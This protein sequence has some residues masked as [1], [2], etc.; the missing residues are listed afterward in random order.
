MIFLF[1]PNNHDTSFQTQAGIGSAPANFGIDNENINL[2]NEKIIREDQ[3][4]NASTLLDGEIVYDDQY[5]FSINNLFTRFKPTNLAQAAEILNTN[6]YYGRHTILPVSSLGKPINCL[7]VDVYLPESNVT[8]RWPYDNAY[9][10][11][12]G[13]FL[14][15]L[16]YRPTSLIYM[17]MVRIMECASEVDMRDPFSIQMLFQGYYGKLI[18]G[19]VHL[20]IENFVKDGKFIFNSEYDIKEVYE[21]CFDDR[22][23]QFLRIEK[24]KV[25]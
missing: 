1:Y 5:K 9:N 13:K 12:T 17:S 25:K 15:K 20:V 3:Q 4:V 8:F 21:N 7:K 2:P 24:I 18:T 23:M 22:E 10:M 19:A 6:G 11:D 16:S 14:K